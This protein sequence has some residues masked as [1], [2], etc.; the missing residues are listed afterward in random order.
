MINKGIN[1]IIAIIDSGAVA[2]NPADQAA[3]DLVLG[4]AYAIRA[5]AHFDLVRAFGQ[6]FTI[7][8]ASPGVP[9]VIA[10]ACVGCFC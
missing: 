9:V 7:A 4:K 3:A 2:I 6:P 5:I 10:V 1:N 8:P